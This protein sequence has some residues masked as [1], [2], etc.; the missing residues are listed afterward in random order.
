MSGHTD[1]ALAANRRAYDALVGVAEERLAAG[2]AEGVLHVATTAAHLAWMMPVGRLADPR[3]EGLVA[4]AVRGDAPAPEVGGE[5]GTGRVLHVLTEA[6]HL[7]GHSRLA[8]RW[9]ERDGRPADVAITAPL[10]A[11]LP[12][13]LPAAVAASGGTVH[14]VA[15]PGDTLLDRARALA[16][17]M[18]RADTVVLHTHPYDVVALAAAQLGPVRPPIVTQNHV[19][20]AYWLG[21][22]V[23][24]VVVN[25]RAT[26]AR[27]CVESRGVPQD[28]LRLL[29]LPVEPPAGP[30]DR[31]P[32][33]TAMRL[34][35][36]TPVAVCVGTTAKLSPM[37]GVSFAEVL[38]KVLAAVPELVVLVVGPGDAEPW[39]AL[40]ARYPGRLVP[41]GRVDELG[42][43]FAAADVYLDSYPV[44]GGTAVLE[45]A[46]SGLPV[47]CLQETARYSE[48][49]ASQS[50]GLEDP[51]HRVPDVAALVEELRSM[52][53]RPKERRRRGI[54]TRNAVLRAHRG[55]G[56]LAALGEVYEAARSVAPASVDE[57]GETL[58]DPAYVAELLEFTQG[59]VA[60]PP[61]SRA[62]VAPHGVMAPPELQ[63]AVL[64]AWL[65]AVAP[66]EAVRL[67]L[68]AHPEW[69]EDREWTRR[70]VELTAASSAVGLSLTVRPEDAEDA[71]AVLLACMAEV[72]VGPET[73][74]HVSL[75]SV[76]DPVGPRELVLHPDGWTVDLATAFAQLAGDP[77]RPLAEV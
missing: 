57:L 50:P 42:R 64:R 20:H 68:R 44:S 69:A 5:R 28:R 77:V 45:A 21:L 38:D 62:L 48:V 36:D 74:G 75:D 24:D 53:H 56:W 66:D 13:A 3:L 15:R 35:P 11:E 14:V 22:S 1:R 17:L 25:H 58:L 73:C 7:G 51:A 30:N 19:D 39:P 12:P 67:R 6:Y 41:L 40:A 76:D 49:W 34:G 2:D 55:D 37:F 63:A 72:G 52:V 47:L 29:P 65:V 31:G 10:R 61:L 70:M 43:L 16:G 33:R 26:G 46:A 27:L 18:A 71:L 32:V 60:E 59:A 4:R 23:S 8:W 54:R 9:I